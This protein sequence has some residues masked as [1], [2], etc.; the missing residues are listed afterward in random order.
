MIY[1]FEYHKL[2]RSH[3]PSYSILSIVLYLFFILFGFYTYAQTET[4]G[5]VTFRYTFENR[6]YFNGL[7]FALYAFY[8][9][10]MMVLPIFAATEGGAQIAGET[11]KRTLYLMLARPLSRS[12]I[13]FSKL[14]VSF[15]YLFILVGFLLSFALTIGLILVGWGTL[16]LYPGVLQM[17][18]V[19]QSLTQNQALIAFTYAWIL[20][21]ISLSAPLA[22]SFYLSTWIRNPLNAVSTSIAIYLILYVMSEIHFF[23]KLRPYF[24]TSYMGFWREVFREN[25]L[26]DRV[27]EDASCILMF[28]FAFL[29]LAHRQFR[30]REEI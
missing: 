12:R 6:S 13:F 7:T 2:Q 23:A 15:L 19:H 22:M 9:A 20:A 21:T 30:L 27:F 16:N 1:K 25:I 4:G 17:T 5:Q 3:R 28:T 11:S 10:V 24:F 8:F 18:H 29:A 26:W 14:L